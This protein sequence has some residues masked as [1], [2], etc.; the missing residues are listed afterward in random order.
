M[1]IAT[2]SALFA[3]VS[4]VVALPADDASSLA[5]RSD[6]PECQPCIDKCYENEAMEDPMA[7]QWANCGLIVR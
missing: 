5:A 4:S 6:Y 7:C 3:L 2:F 1:K